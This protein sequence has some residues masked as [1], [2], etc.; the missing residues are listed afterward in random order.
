MEGHIVITVR[1]EILWKGKPIEDCNGYELRD[2]I[3][4]AALEI[5][6]LKPQEKQPRIPQWLRGGN[7]D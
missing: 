1:Q 7:S 4:W 2:A 5:E 3:R 6:R